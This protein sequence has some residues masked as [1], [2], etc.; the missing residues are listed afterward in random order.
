M[1]Q[2]LSWKVDYLLGKK[3][4]ASMESECLVCFYEHILLDLILAHFNSITA[5][6]LTRHTHTYTHTYLYLYVCNGTRL[7]KNCIVV[8]TEKPRYSVLLN[9]LFCDRCDMF[10]CSYGDKNVVVRAG[11]AINLIDVS[12]NLMWPVDQ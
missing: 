9:S 4:P 5:F 12:E 10:T 3:L 1:V 8:G 2:G 11:Q 6:L 7:L